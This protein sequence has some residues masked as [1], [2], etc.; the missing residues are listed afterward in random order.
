MPADVLLWLYVI[1]AVLGFIAYGLYAALCTSRLLAFLADWQDR[2]GLPVDVLFVLCAV[3]C[4]V[5]W[6]LLGL[7]FAAGLVVERRATRG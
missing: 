6:P 1:P 3:A 5:G 7:F 2:S 4:S